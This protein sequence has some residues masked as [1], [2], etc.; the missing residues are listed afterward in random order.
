MEDETAAPAVAAGS[1]GGFNPS[2]VDLGGA[3]EAQLPPEAPGE[4]AVSD[5][6]AEPP[7]ETEEEAAT[8]IAE[9]EAFDAHERDQ[10]EAAAQAETEA[11]L[12][13]IPAETPTDQ[14]QA[15]EAGTPLE[16]ETPAAP[17]EPE[18]PAA[19]AAPEENPPAAKPKTAKKPA[20]KAKPAAKKA[21]AKRAYRVLRPDGEDSYVVVGTFEVG[22]EEAALRGALAAL[23]DEGGDEEGWV[24]LVAVPTSYMRARRLRPKKRV[25]TSVEFA[26]E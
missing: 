7:V 14:P 12:A 18:A 10:A 20:A 11:A 4:E 15:P 13:A 25:S 3:D 22:T 17:A 24:E 8:R 23:G 5:I 21:T 1:L 16:P 9:Q 26:D 6:P 2:D 19:A